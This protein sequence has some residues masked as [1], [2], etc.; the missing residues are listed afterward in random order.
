M[1]L[2]TGCALLYRVVAEWPDHWL[3][4]AATRSVAEGL[5]AIFLLVGFGTPFWGAATAA[6]QLWRIH[7]G[8]DEPLTHAL[9]ATLGVSLA[10]LGA[11]ASSVDAWIFGWRRI[12]VA[13]ARRDQDRLAP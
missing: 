2:A 12:D 7:S 11:G 4:L 5:A 8:M 6:L 3:S 10:L 1:R 13:K 9:L